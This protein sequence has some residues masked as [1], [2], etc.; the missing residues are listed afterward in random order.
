ML[1]ATITQLE[2]A[3]TIIAWEVVVI[4]PL[5]VFVYLA[6]SMAAE[7]KMSNNYGGYNHGDKP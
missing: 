1:L 5:G 2:V 4:F 3:I 7:R 6:R